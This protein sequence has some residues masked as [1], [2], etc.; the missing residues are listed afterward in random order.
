MRMGHGRTVEIQINRCHIFQVMSG[1]G[2]GIRCDQTIDLAKC[3]V[4]MV[5]YGLQSSPQLFFH[6]FRK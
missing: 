1:G 3:K 2:D 5:S 4:G 6:A